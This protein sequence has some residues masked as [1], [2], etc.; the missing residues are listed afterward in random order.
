MKTFI[1]YIL[2]ITIGIMLLGEN[3][4]GQSS[5]IP[6]NLG[7]NV[8]SAYS[9]INP[10]LSTDGKTLYFTRVNHPENTVGKVNS[11]DVWFSTLNDDGTW[12]EAKRLPKEVNIGRYNSILAALSDGKT[13]MINGVYNRKGTMW[14][15]RGF[16]LIEKN[17]STWGKPIPIKV[18]GFA[19]KNR[20]RAATAYITPD[21]EYLFISF[22]PS[23]NSAK[24]TIYVSKKKEENRYSK[25]KALKGEV[26]N[27]RSAEA[28]FL[29]GDGNTLYYSGNFKGKR[30]SYDFYKST[31]TD[32]TYINWS[33][34]ELLTDSTNTPDWDS[35][36]KLNAKG[37]WAYYCSVNKS[38]GKSDIFRVKIFEEN[39]YVKVTGLILNKQTEALMLTDTSYQILV[40]GKPFPG[41]K[42]DKASAS[43]EALLPFDSLYSIKPDMNNWIGM[44]SEVD[45]RG[46]KEY[47]ES[48]LNLYLETKPY[49]LVKGNIIDTRTNLPI[50]LEKKP[51]VLIN[52]LASD[53]VKYDSL[54]ASYRVLLPLDSIYIFKAKVPNFVGK[55]DTVNVKNET[56]YREREV[57]LYV[58][59]NPWVEVKGIALDNNT[60]TPIIGNP[61][62]KL[63]IDGAIADSIKIDAATGEFTIRLPFG[64]QYRTAISAK[65][66]SP[67]ENILDLSGY[68]EFNTVKHNVFGEFKDANMAILN[69]KVINTKTNQPLEVGIPVKLKIN[70]VISRAFKYDSVK[71]EYTLKLPVGY[72]YDLL[73]SVYN[74]YNKFEPLDLTKVKAKT[75]I[76]K[77]FYVTPIEVGQSVDIEHIY[78]E[79]AKA[80]LKPSS[81]K[82]LNALVAF[83]NEYPNVTVEIS[84]HTDNTGTAAINMSISEKRAKS[85]ADYVVSQGVPL[86]RVVSKGYGLTKPKYTNKTPQGRAKNRRVEFMITGI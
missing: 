10:I 27:G 31:R 32:A 13:F 50:S 34:P 44:P 78:F 53:S 64:K 42:I 70:G 55:A 19:R 29:S 30:N 39:P 54:V 74:Y 1:Q 72:Y 21:K 85:V 82:S 51:R 58:T 43:Y 36:Y 68:V 25:P 75:K 47:A 80:D 56:V 77:N 17:D 28:P 65:D 9:E 5:F 37:S 84:G 26:N 66:F 76:P 14:L 59:S 11:Q 20:G 46:L 23:N 48:K 73:P 81:F 16:S 8:N 22:A 67:I 38:L 15:E 61:D 63:S 6:H 69:G 7:A 62:I 24:L 40:N 33:K 41:L 52:G 35:Y 86:S 45:T 12:S 18:K 60:L 71:L 2:P 57:N 83:L 49:I 3:T 4:I 79:T